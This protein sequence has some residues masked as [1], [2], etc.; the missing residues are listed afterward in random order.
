MLLKLK[1]EGIISLI[2]LETVSADKTIAGVRFSNL[3]VGLPDLS[4]MRIT[5]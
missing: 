2:M 3:K 5:T 1:Q 4:P